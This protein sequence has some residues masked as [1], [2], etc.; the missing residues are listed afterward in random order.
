MSSRFDG[1]EV[2]QHQARFSG[3]IELGDS[4]DIDAEVTAVIALRVVGGAVNVNSKGDLVRT[5]KLK[6]DRFSILQP[7][8]LLDEAVKV[9]GA[10]PGDDPLPFDDPVELNEPVIPMGQELLGGEESVVLPAIQV[11]PEDRVVRSPQPDPEPEE[12]EEPQQLGA[13]NRIPVGGARANDPKL[14]AFLDGP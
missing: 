14:R 12:D 10:P 9:L 6:V 11:E 3:T 4:L 2:Q 1:L 8:Q 7:G 5:N 13:G